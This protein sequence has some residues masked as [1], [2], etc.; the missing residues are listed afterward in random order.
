MSCFLIGSNTM[1]RLTNYNCRRFI[2]L[3]PDRLQNSMFVLIEQVKRGFNPSYF[4]EEWRQ[5]T[6]T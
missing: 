4:D 5:G 6:A 3:T 1:V 2:K